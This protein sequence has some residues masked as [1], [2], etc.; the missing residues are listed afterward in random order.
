MSPEDSVNDL[1]QI[2]VPATAAFEEEDAWSR[3]D[4][5]LLY[6]PAALPCAAS[7]E[8][9]EGD[10]WV[11]VCSR[12]HRQIYNLSGMSRW[13]AVHFV[14]DAEERLGVQFRR[15]RDG[16][17]LTDNC[18]VGRRQA[19]SRVMVGFS[20]VFLSTLLSL[21]SVLG[22]VTLVAMLGAGVGGIFCVTALDQN[23]L[24]GG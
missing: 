12:C 5:L 23:D 13:D 24:R 17:L 7:W 15:R 21:A 11:R 18:P 2:Q 3:G 20:F 1:L 10:D 6:L 22:L 4:D 16:M 19:R 8:E 14:R 9:M